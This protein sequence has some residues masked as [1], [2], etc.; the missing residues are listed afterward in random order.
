MSIISNISIIYNTKLFLLEEQR[1]KKIDNYARV[2]QKSFQ[3]LFNKQKFLRQKEEA[4]GEYSDLYSKTRLHMNKILLT[5][6]DTS[7][8][9]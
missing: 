9:H 4:A 5:H 3:K 2:I 1:D 6:K 8:I 7:A